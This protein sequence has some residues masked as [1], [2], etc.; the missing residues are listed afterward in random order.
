MQADARRRRNDNYF[1]DTPR[2]KL[3]RQMAQVSMVRVHFISDSISINQH[4]GVLKCVRVGDCKCVVAGISHCE[5]ISD[6]C[7]CVFCS[8]CE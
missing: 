1:E 6:V 2:S 4:C 5:L 8:D 3:E 7:A